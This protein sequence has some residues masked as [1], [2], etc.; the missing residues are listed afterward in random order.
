[1]SKGLANSACR[2][3][4][5]CA[6]LSGM[7]SSMARSSSAVPLT[8]MKGVVSELLQS[9]N[10]LESVLIVGMVRMYLLAAL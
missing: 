6:S 3:A 7:V 4:A 5:A 10:L 1:M 2:L 8:F 9:S